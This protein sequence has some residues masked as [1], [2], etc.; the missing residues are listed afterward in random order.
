M[1]IMQVFIC[2]FDFYSCFNFCCFSAEI[3]N[4]YLCP[5]TMHI[6]QVHISLSRARACELSAGLYGLTFDFGTRIR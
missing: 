2:L 6:M 1:D 3:P 5:I 4:E